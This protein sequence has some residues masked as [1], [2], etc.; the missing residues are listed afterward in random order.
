MHFGRLPELPSSFVGTPKPIV[1]TPF[2]KE[3]WP[4]HSNSGTPSHLQEISLQS[5]SLAEILGQ[6][7]IAQQS[8]REPPPSLQKIKVF[9]EKLIQWRGQLPSHLEIH[10]RSNP[11][12]LVLQCAL[13][14]LLFCCLL[15]LLLGIHSCRNGTQH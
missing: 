2:E 3:S 11:A 13:S 1:I 4:P 14:S 5:Y 15:S 12:V 8:P 6:I 10:E 7:L 9:H